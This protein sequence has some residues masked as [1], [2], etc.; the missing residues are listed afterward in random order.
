MK[1]RT[2]KCRPTGTHEARSA[3]VPAAASEP[4]RRGPSDLTRA[5]SNHFST[6]QYSV[7]AVAELVVGPSTAKRLAKQ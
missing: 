7:E 6:H 4:A 1:F 3:P 5:W 2:A